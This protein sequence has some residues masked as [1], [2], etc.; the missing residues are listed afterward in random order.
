MTISLLEKFI[1][2]YGRLPTEVDPDY[3]ELVRMSKFRILST[4]DVSPGKCANCGASKDDKRQ[5]V[6]VG[7]QVDF[8][9]AVFLCGFCVKELATEMG[10]FKPLQETIEKLTAITHDNSEL[11][12]VGEE[13]NKTLIKTF[14]EMRT[15]YASVLP[16]QPQPV[17]D[18][19]AGVGPTKETN[20]KS[21]TDE[22]KPRIT[23][24]F[25]VIGS[26]DIPSLA[27]LLDGPNS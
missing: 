6:D 15:F 18:S 17:S 3:L 23:K 27:S 9:G 1:E 11:V 4:P 2:R 26:K 24:P 5:Y 7:L 13:L 21:G 22:S 10:L 8:Y 19:I 20:S 25:D 16:S 14:E 12:R